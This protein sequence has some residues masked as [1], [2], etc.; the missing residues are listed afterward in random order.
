MNLYINNRRYI[1]SKKSLLY[2]IEKTV[3]TYYGN[4]KCIFTDLFGGTGVVGEYFSSLG[5]DVIINDFLYSNYIAYETWISNEKFDQ[6]IIENTID[7]FNLING[8]DLK[9]NYFSK[10]FGG[11]YFSINDAKKIGYIREEIEKQKKEISYRE[12]CILLTSLMYATDKIANTVGHFEHYLSKEPIDK[13]VIL[14][15]PTINNDRTGKSYIYNEDSN[16]LIRKIKTDIVYIDPPYNARQYINFY[17]VLENLVRWEKPEELE[18]KSMKFKRNH[19]KSDYSKSKATEVFEDLIINIRAKLII[20]S[21][22]NTYNA[23]SGASNNKIKEEDL[24]KIL[25][26]KG[27][28]DIIEIDYKSFNTGKTNFND[29]KEK[30]YVCVVK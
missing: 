3:K 13:G 24:Y 27:K 20:V 15:I 26:E 5:Y 14:R 12:Y 19:L 25:S 2:E 1:G 8:Q 7:Q 18:G 22:N 16:S 9:S 21:Y 6:T 4:N 17:H 28:T 23:N 30:L 11:K 29:H 10:V